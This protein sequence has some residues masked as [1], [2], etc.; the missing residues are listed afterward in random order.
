[1][2]N[3][4]ILTAL[5]FTLVSKAQVPQSAQLVGEY[6]FNSNTDDSSGNN[7]NGQT[8]GSPTQVQDRFGN[9]NAAFSLDGVDDYI[10]FGNSMLSEWPYETNGYIMES[11]TISIWAKSSVSANEILLAFGEDLGCCYYGM[12]TT[13]GT[14]VK[15]TSSNF[16]FYSNNSGVNTSGK[17]YDNQWHHYVVVW[18][19]DSGYRRIY[20]DGV[21]EGQYQQV[22]GGNIRKRFKVS[23]YGLAVGRD[24][25]NPSNPSYLGDTYN[26]SVD[27]VRIW[28]TDLSST[29]IS[30]L[31]TYDS[32]SMNYQP[33][34]FNVVNRFGQPSSTAGEQL[35]QY[36]QIGVGNTFVNKNGKIISF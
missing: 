18:D 24:R 35:N 7:Y 11:F 36:G 5:L 19:Y 15:M 12:V 17:G 32:D 23:N 28:N 25:Y 6:T 20:I 1:M 8:Y 26:G 31:Y 13:V 4:F 27:E 30:N 29:D 34:T 16:P 33:T 21:L 3:Y 22:E 9:S 2:K 10:Y 14:H